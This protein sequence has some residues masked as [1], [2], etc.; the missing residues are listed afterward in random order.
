MVGRNCG[1]SDH[2]IARIKLGRRRRGWTSVE[3]A[4]LRSSDELVADH[5]IIDATWA[6]LDELLNKGRM[7]GK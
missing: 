3:A 2:E 5:F 1:L 4:A 7:H 6:A